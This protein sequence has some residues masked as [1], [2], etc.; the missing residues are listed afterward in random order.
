VGACH[1]YTHRLT[2]DRVL[3]WRLAPNTVG[4]RETNWRARLRRCSQWQFRYV[5]PARCGWTAQRLRPSPT[6]EATRF[7]EGQADVLRRRIRSACWFSNGSGGAPPALSRWRRVLRGSAGAS[8]R[9]NPT[10]SRARFPSHSV[11]GRAPMKQNSP[12]H[13]CSDMSPV[14]LSVRG[15]SLKATTPPDRVG[16][17][18]VDRGWSR[19]GVRSR[20]NRYD[21]IVAAT[22]DPTHRQSHSAAPRRQEQGGLSGGVGPTHHGHR[23][24][25]ARR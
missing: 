17:F 7:T 11:A 5:V 13:R 24:G 16:D 9:M 6:A 3:Y 10:L 19:G 20:S 23:L 2:L 18:G 4:G 21:D 12:A 8:V 14:G 22:S 1:L 25:A 15:D